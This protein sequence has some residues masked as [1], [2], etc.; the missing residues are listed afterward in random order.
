VTVALTAP[1]NRR[2]MDQNLSLLDDWRP[3]TPEELERLR[4]H[5]DRVRRHAGL[6]W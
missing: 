4:A 3:P 6:F 2:E 5:G 1:G